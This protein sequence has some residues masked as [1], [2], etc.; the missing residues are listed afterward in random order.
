MLSSELIGEYSQTSTSVPAAKPSLSS[1][2][3]TKPSARVVEEST[4][5]ATDNK[6]A[7]TKP[8]LTGD[9][10]LYSLADL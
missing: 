2:T 10:D 5:T 1:G 6:P 7:E 8:G 3:I 4:E 9:P